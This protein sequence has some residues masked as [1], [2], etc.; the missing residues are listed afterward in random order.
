MAFS[1]ESLIPV[2]LRGYKRAW[3]TGD[4][5]AGV[6]LA[7]VA[8]PETMGYTSIA[9]TPVVTGLYT[10]IFPTLAFALL[11]LL[12]AA[13]RGRRLGDGRDHGR[14]AR[15]ARHRRALAELAGVARLREPGGPGL[16]WAAVLARLLKLGFLGDFLSASVL[17]G[18]LTG[19][20]IQVLTGQI[21]GM[22]GIPK[23]TGNWF[24]QQWYTLTH[25]AD[26][27]G[28]T[29]A[30][31][32]GTLIIILGC[33][34]FA[35]KVP[36][37]VDRGGPVD[38][39]VQRAGLQR[40]RRRRHRAGPGRLPAHRPARGDHLE[41]H[42]RPSWGSPCPASSSSSPRALRRPAASR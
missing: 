36:G 4:V 19:V 6:T 41:R 28:P 22:L 31:A 8:I 29:V 20:G 14:R 34:R 3:L 15:R 40:Q 42:T 39:R 5:V 17:I 37:A 25:L 30:Y 21:P 11:G 38:R 18:F 9:Q 23:G 24:Q 13:G 33:K 12:A 7:A 16:R 2:A 1:R 10:I 27:S 32:A 26:A 35:P